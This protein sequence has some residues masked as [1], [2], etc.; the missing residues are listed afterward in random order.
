MHHKMKLINPN[1]NSIDEIKNG[2]KNIVLINSQYTNSFK[3]PFSNLM[4]RKIM[5]RNKIKSLNLMKK[6]L[7]KVKK[8]NNE[9]NGK[10]VFKQNNLYI[11]FS[12]YFEQNKYNKNENNNQDNNINQK[13]I[14]IKIGNSFDENNVFKIFRTK[15]LS[16][17]RKFYKNRNI[18]PLKL[19]PPNRT[20]NN[21]KITS[22]SKENSEKEIVY[23]NNKVVKINKMNITINNVPKLIHLNEKIIQTAKYLLPK[24]EENKIHNK[25]NSRNKNI[26]FRN[27]NT[28]NSNITNNINSDKTAQVSGYSKNSPK[29]VFKNRTNNE[30]IKINEEPYKSISAERFNNN[31][32]IENHQIH[33]RKII[34]LWK[35][36]KKEYN[37]INNSFS[38]EIHKRKISRLNIFKLLSL[39]HKK[40][41]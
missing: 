4:L 16:T 19:V 35:S 15:D 37:T 31:M 1:N 21:L 11:N 39:R 22:Y 40:K 30:I 17:I 36:I 20:I 25:F 6:G 38:N 28:N 3:N 12:D 24:I 7:I 10:K 18:R 34:N 32:D 33:K 29:R 26:L 14:D 2:P 8:E 13:N 9:N 27:N 5:I 23:I 41:A